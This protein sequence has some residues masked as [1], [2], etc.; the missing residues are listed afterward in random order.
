MGRHIY[1]RMPGDV[2]SN[3]AEVPGY[4]TCCYVEIPY[5]KTIVNFIIN[6]NNGGKQLI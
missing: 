1:K 2:M 5:G 4:G 3:T 6:N